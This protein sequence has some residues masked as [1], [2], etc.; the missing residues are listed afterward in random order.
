MKFL[1]VTIVKKEKKIEHLQPW[2]GACTKQRV[3]SCLVCKLIRYTNNYIFD[4]SKYMGS[5][6][7]KKN[8]VH[9]GGGG[10]EEGNIQG[11]KSIFLFFKEVIF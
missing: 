3:E 11:L 8:N 7:L 6:A 5:V 4:Y 1:Y 10:R 2:P 9:K